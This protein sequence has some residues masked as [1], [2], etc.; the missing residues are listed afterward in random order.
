MY[1]ARRGNHELRWIREKMEIICNFLFCVFKKHLWV[2]KKTIKR[3]RA[4]PM[5]LQFELVSF[6]REGKTGVLEEKPLGA[7][8]RT[9]NKL[10]SHMGST[11]RPDLNPSHSLAVGGECT[12][13]CRPEMPLPKLSSWKALRQFNYPSLISKATQRVQLIAL[14]Q[15]N[16]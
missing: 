4:F 15:I 12:H 11:P 3:A 1:V 13:H 6:W 14:T 5:E 8:R 10:N 9:N 7:K 2:L 16:I